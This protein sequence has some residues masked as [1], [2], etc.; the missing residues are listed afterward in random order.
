MKNIYIILLTSLLF[1][2]ASGISK[3]TNF[4]A[5]SKNG[6]VV[7]SMDSPFSHID[8]ISLTQIDPDTCHTLGSTVF[9]G[10]NYYFE[11][12]EKK[13]LMD[14]FEPGVWI[15]RKVD[16]VIGNTKTRMYFNKGAIAFKINAGEFTHVGKLNFSKYG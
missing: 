1:G 3:S 6:L 13:F 15:I 8:S 16:L 9:N 11:L 4:D 10:R 5:T 7:I 12:V 2:C 14:T